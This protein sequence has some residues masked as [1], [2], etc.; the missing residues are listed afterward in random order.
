[1]SLRQLDAGSQ[2]SEIEMRDCLKSNVATTFELFVVA[3]IQLLLVVVGQ[4]PLRASEIRTDSV[5]P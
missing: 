1:M 4:G 3:S 2:D 5:R